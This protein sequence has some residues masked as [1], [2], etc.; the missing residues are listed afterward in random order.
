MFPRCRFG[1]MSIETPAGRN[2]S[3]ASRSLRVAIMAIFMSTLASVVPFA[4]AQPAQ[5]AADGSGGP[6]DV[7]DQLLECYRHYLARNYAAYLRCDDRLDA[8]VSAS[9]ADGNVRSGVL[10]LLA[11][12]RF[13]LLVETEQTV[14]AARVAERA[15]ELLPKDARRPQPTSPLALPVHGSDEFKRFRSALRTAG[16]KAAAAGLGVDP[17][18][19]AS[20]VLGVNA[21]AAI[22]SE[23]ARRLSILNQ[24]LALLGATGAR[25]RRRIAFMQGRYDAVVR[26][27]RD[28]EEILRGE[29]FGSAV[30]ALTSIAGVAIAASLSP[31]NV[32]NAASAYSGAAT[33][34]VM[35]LGI[36]LF[37]LGTD[38]MALEVLGAFWKRFDTAVDQYV[39]AKSLVEKGDHDAAGRLL[40]RMLEWPDLARIGALYWSCLYERGRVAYQRGDDAKGEEFLR[41]AIDEIERIRST[42]SFEA[43]K[44]GFLRDKQV[45]YARLVE[46]LTRAGRWAEAFDFVERA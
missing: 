38:A 7:G 21:R 4:V 18:E 8:A 2:R 17:G 29:R 16:E 24:D 35:N 43:A 9:G 11:P 25:E 13:E 33:Q 39:L 12:M 28:H 32:F 19:V 14:E 40:D 22:L 42:I 27:Y 6:T 1:D 23:N 5:R 34:G 46:A 44:I 26:M 36:S 20:R 45:V 31:I 37:S 3:S 10:A 15:L 30:M 41:R